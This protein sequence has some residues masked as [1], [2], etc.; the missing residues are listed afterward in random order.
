MKL[1]ITSDT[2]LEF[3]ADGGLAFIEELSSHADKVDVLVI[4]GDFAGTGDLSFCLSRLC[5]R[6]KKVVYVSGNHEAYGCTLAG[7][8]NIV[9]GVAGACDNLTYLD[10]KRVVI[11]GQG[12]IGG[13]LWFPHKPENVLYTKYLSDFNMIREFDVHSADRECDATQEAIMTHCQAGD[14]VVTHHLPH[15]LSIDRRYRNEAGDVLNRFFL[16]NMDKFM[17]SGKA[18]LWFHGHTHEACDYEVYGTRVICNPLGYP[19]EPNPRY[20]NPMI[21]EV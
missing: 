8:R 13:T 15:P 5:A 1:L 6:F 21:V 10:N 7:V 4:A 11:D 3:H 16:C 18:K 14:I 20:K 19:H 12:F 17:Q 9:N 2:H